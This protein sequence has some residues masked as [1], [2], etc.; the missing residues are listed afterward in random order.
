MISLEL[1]GAEIP[2]MDV[3]I[4]ARG[5]KTS[6]IFT[7]KKEIHYLKG[8]LADLDLGGSCFST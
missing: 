2:H 5:K 6:E 4:P 7:R 1:H 3:V 8:T